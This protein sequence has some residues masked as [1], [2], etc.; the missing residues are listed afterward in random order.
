MS[1]RGHKINDDDVDDDAMTRA[2]SMA[3][4]FLFSSAELVH[5]EKRLK[6]MHINKVYSACFP[7]LEPAADICISPNKGTSNCEAKNDKLML[8][9]RRRSEGKALQLWI[10][11]H[12]LTGN[13]GARAGPSRGLQG[14]ESQ[15]L[16]LSSVSGA[17]APGHRENLE[18]QAISISF[19]P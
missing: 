14:G 19:N 13:R 15:L 17:A 3:L 9:A 4:A 5:N 10:N 8:D 7:A 6:F 16:V 18:S 11:S 2:E 1:R 12:F